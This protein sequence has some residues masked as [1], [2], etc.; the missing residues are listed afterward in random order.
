MTLDQGEHVDELILAELDGALSAV[1][2]KTIESHVMR[3]DRCAAT[4]MEQRSIQN[5]VAGP[6]ISSMDLARGHDLV[7]RR[8]VEPRLAPAAGFW[9][10]AWSA[11]ALAA[12][13]ALVVGVALTFI[14]TQSAARPDSRA[15]VIAQQAVAVGPGAGTVTVT[16]R[17]GPDS[18]R[19]VVVASD[20]RFAPS[21]TKGV[22]EVR[23]QRTGESYGI[24]AAIPTLAGVS[25]A[26]TEGIVPPPASASDHYDVWVHVEIDGR[27]YDSAPIP[28]RITSDRTG[29]HARPD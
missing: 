26:R 21:P 28:L 5:T 17:L 25:A 14:V 8:L 7:W 15:V 1:E 10:S 12:T 11:V 18:A 29:T 16:E 23:L 3:C 27:V 9:R 6:P 20:L 13:I 22:L 24:L 2:R 4:R 19:Q